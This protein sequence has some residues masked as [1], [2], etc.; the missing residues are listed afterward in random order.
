MRDSYEL[1]YLLGQGLPI[2]IIPSEMTPDMRII[3]ATKNGT[4]YPV[5]K[6]L[7]EVQL[8]Y[9]SKAYR[10]LLKHDYAGMRGCAMSKDTVYVL[11]TDNNRTIT[12][13]HRPPYVSNDGKFIIY[14]EGYHPSPVKRRSGITYA[15]LDRLRCAQQD[16][17]A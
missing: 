2:P 6:A 7:V 3:N 4:P 9:S 5:D 8:R 1:F 16:Q 12:I 15:M 17:V 11:Y 13:A 14:G 10:A